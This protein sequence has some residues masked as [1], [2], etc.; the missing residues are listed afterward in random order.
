MKRSLY[1]ERKI[2]SIYILILLVFSC[3]FSPDKKYF[4]SNNRYN[5]SKEV[6]SFY[7]KLCQFPGIIMLKFLDVG[8]N[9]KSKKTAGFP[10]DRQNFSFI[11][12]MPSTF[13]LYFLFKFYVV[14]QFNKFVKSMNGFILKILLLEDI[15][16]FYMSRL[17]GFIYCS[18]IEGIGLFRIRF[19]E[20]LTPE[21][22]YKNGFLGLFFYK[23]V[24]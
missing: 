14:K 10:G 23:G 9:E 3:F 24:L 12:L 4:L 7:A 16:K 13:L 22:H 15:F 1:L 2:I 8:S 20:V 19:V 11:F 21:G 5:F 6:I 17:L 18:S